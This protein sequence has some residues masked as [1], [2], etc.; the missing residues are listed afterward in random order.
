MTLLL[1]AIPLLV[2]AAF[3]YL[4]HVNRGM[5]EVPEETRLLSPNRW[6]DD[7]I[8]AAYKKNLEN[9]IDVTKS[10]PPKQT[11]RYIVVGGAGNL[12]TNSSN[13]CTNYLRSCR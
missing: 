4:D 8:K 1:L 2:G 13:S 10:L 5:V 3:L 6:T 7:E 12:P 9:P 11:R